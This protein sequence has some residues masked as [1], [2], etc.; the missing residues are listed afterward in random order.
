MSMVE[1][2]TFKFTPTAREPM[3]IHQDC[4]RKTERRHEVMT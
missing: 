3:T 4:F 2:D 1:K